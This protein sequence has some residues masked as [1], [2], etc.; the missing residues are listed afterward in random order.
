MTFRD[1][2]RALLAASPADAVLSVPAPWLADL[3]GDRDATGQ[4]DATA[5]AVDLTV[6]EVA[7]RFNRGASTIRTWC[8]SGALPGAYR[9]NLREWRIPASAIEAMQRT[10]AARHRTPRTAQTTR[11]ANISA[12]RAHLPAPG[13]Q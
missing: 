8:E 10:Q 7:A 9:L 12:W 11:P 6:K 13:T 3:L 4:P 1:A 5:H 2:L